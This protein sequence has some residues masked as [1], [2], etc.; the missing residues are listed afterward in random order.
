MPNHYD[1]DPNEA[2]DTA[3]F[4]AQEQATLMAVSYTHLTLTTN[5]EV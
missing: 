2:I 3:N 5:R 1:R 4:K